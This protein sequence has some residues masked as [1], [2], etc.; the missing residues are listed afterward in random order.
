M[1]P[2]RGPGAEPELAHQVVAVDREIAAV[3]DD[4]S[5]SSSAATRARSS[6]SPPAS[7]GRPRPDV[8]GLAQREQLVERLARPRRLCR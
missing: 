5:A 2:S 1:R 8:V 6:S 4:A 3:E 7:G